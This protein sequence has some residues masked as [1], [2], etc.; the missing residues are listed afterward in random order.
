LLKIQ[1]FIFIIIIRLM[2]NVQKSFIHTKKR[3][4]YVVFRFYFMQKILTKNP[5][6]THNLIII[7][8]FEIEV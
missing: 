3:Q 4:N 2:K 8:F 1:V 6:L 5:R 7:E